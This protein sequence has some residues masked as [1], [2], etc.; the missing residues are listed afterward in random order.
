MNTCP[1][2]SQAIGPNDLV[3]PKCGISL[4][5]GTATAGPASGGGKGTSVFLI[6]GVG[7]V[8]IVLVLACLGILGARFY[9]ARARMSAALSA[10]AAPVQAGSEVDLKAEELEVYIDEMPAEESPKDESTKPH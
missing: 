5:P 7:L 6:V 9:V 8:G 10:V 4:H 3:C 1:A 2:C